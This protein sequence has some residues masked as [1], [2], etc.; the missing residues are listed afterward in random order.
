MRQDRKNTKPSGA[1]M[2][3]HFSGETYSIWPNG[4]RYMPRCRARMRPPL[5][6][7]SAGSVVIDNVNSA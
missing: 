2:I 1:S 7:A 5:D 6:A 4:V 3:T